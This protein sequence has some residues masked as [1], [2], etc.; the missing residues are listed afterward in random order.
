MIKANFSTNL[1]GILLISLSWEIFFTYIINRFSG[2]RLFMAEK[3]TVNS[4]VINML[5]R[6]PFRN[7]FNT[8]MVDVEI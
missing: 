8:L 3:Q 1:R 2:P 6:L 7:H 5:K 4:T